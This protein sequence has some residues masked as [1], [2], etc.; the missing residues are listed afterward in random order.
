[1]RALVVTGPGKAE[2]QETEPPIAGPGEVIVDVERVGVCGTDMELFSGEMSYLHSGRSWYPLR[3]GHE[4]CGTV[5]ALGEGVQADWL[6]RRVT[7]DTM[8]GCGR[9]HRCRAGHHHICADV[10]EIGISR[11]RPGA[12]AEQLAVP[13]SALQPLPDTVD[14]TLGALVEPGGNALRAIESTGLA[15]GERLLVLGTGTIGLLAALFA[16]ARGIE[17]HLLGRDP[18]GLRLARTLGF[19]GAWTKPSLPELAW[20]AVVDASNAP[21]LPALALE[22]VEPAGRVVCIGLA[23]TPSAID[24]RHLVL[25]DVTAVGVLGGSAGLAGAIDAYAGGSVDARPLVAATV[26]LAETAGV[27][28]GRRPPSAGP[29]PKIHIDPRQ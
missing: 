13:A 2:V 5:T 21:G 1:M 26:G 6:G 23:G 22:L 25:K 27:L 11:G 15:A 9:C 7:G 24:T 12:L 3:P 28:A 14:L 17:V 20:H 16:R 29:G 4:W 19:E 10:A 18:E 8:L